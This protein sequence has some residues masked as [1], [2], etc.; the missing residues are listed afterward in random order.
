MLSQNIYDG[1]FWITV[2]CCAVAQLFILRAVFRVTPGTTG[3]GSTAN[4]A[5]TNGFTASSPEGESV[6]V[7]SP[8]RLTEIVW[9]VLPVVLLALAFVGTWRVMHPALPDWL[10]PGAEI[11]RR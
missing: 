2:A 3:N 1:I 8:H 11:I 6:S 4:G 9:V 5:N 7:P 10:P